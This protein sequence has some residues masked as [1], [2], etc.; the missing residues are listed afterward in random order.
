VVVAI[1]SSHAGIVVELKRFAWMSPDALRKVC[2][3]TVAGKDQNAPSHLWNGMIVPL[4]KYNIKA[5]LWYQGESNASFPPE[6][7]SIF[8]S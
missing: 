2:N 6:R 1:R 8:Q 7:V 3:D 5:A 4:L